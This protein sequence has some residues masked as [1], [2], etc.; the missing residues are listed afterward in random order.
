[1]KTKLIIYAALMFMISGCGHAL[2]RNYLKSPSDIHSIKSV[3]VLPFENLTK[4]PDAGQIV[5][6]LF[7]TE[8][9]QSTDLKIIDR[10]QARRIMRENKIGAPKVIDRR[11]AQKIGKLLEVDGVFVGSV[12]EYW[13]RLDRRNYRDQGDEPAVGINARLV[14]VASGEVIWASSHSRSSQDILR[15]DRDHINRVAQMAVAAMVGSLR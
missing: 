4:F 12:S 1:M 13:Y 8:L 3:A 15:E 6:T 9:Y 2:Q 11:L 14:D 5:A 10:N 7:T